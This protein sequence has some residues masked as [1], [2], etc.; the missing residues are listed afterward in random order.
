MISKICD[1][2]KTL[3]AGTSIK[4][5]IT[6]IHSVTD[7]NAYENKAYLQKDFVNFVKRIALLESTHKQS[8]SSET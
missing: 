1:F 5:H 4:I 8:Q 3:I 6:D 7:T 2:P